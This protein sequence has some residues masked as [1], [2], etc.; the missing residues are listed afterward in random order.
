MSLNVTNHTN[1]TFCVIFVHKNLITETQDEIDIAM[2]LSDTKRLFVPKMGTASIRDDELVDHYV[3]VSEL[4]GMNDCISL[5]LNPRGKR[6]IKN[7]DS[8]TKK[9][10]ELDI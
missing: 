2:S 1:N 9:M 3:V 6:V 10:R 4:R 5:G 7:F 8:L